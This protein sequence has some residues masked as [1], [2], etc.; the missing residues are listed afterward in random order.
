M[1][2]LAIDGAGD[3]HPLLRAAYRWRLLIILFVANALS[4]T[5][6]A[7]L[8][9]AVEP[10]RHELGLSDTQ[11]GLLQGL[12]FAVTYSLMGIPV[13]RLAERFDRRRIIAVTIVFFSV[14]TGLCGLAGGFFQLFLLRVLVG[15]GEGGFMSPATSLVADHY[16]PDRRASALAVVLCGTPVGFFVGS[17]AGGRI[18]QVWG[19]RAMFLTMSIPGIVIAALVLF[20]LFESPRGLAEGTHQRPAVPVPSLKVVMRYLFGQSAFRQLLIGAVLCTC[21]ANAIGQFQLTFYMRSYGLTLSQSGALTGVIS[22]VSLGIGMLVG[23]NVVDRIQR[24]DPRWYLWGPAIGAALG[25]LLY[26]IGFAQAHVGSAVPFIVV[27]GTFLFFY[28]APSYALVQLIA[29][30]RMRASA[31]AIYGVFSGLLGAGLGPTIAGFISSHFSRTHFAAGDFGS[32]CKGGHA[33]LIGGTVDQ[34]CRAAAAYGMRAAMLAA[35]VFMLWGAL[36]FLIGA[37][38]IG[39]ALAIGRSQSA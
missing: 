8:S 6:R 39:R 15:V 31:V 11:I 37:S 19:W 12:A 14:A 20:A 18:A 35:S 34:A 33:A 3:T 27:G 16:R 13:G 28:F 22:L 30:V 5:D 32:L 36:H 26:A 24:L 38:G 29:G 7:I 4:F 2:A 25:G 23:G 10:M 21:G 1:D 17:L 9:V